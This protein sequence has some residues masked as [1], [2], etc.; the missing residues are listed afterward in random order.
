[1]NKALAQAEMLAKKMRD[2]YISVEH[3]FYELIGPSPTG[4]LGDV[5]RKHGIEKVKIFS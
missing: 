1:M 2:E 5:F 4:L 3:L